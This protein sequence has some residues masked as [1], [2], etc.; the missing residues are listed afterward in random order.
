MKS[1]SRNGYLLLVFSMLFHQNSNAQKPNTAYPESRQV[2]Q[3]DTYHGT[4][5]ND[6]YRWLED[7][8]A[9]ETT[10]WVNR[11]NA[12]TLA[13]LS[14]IPFRDSLKTE[15][16]GYW[17][18]VRYQTPFRCGDNFFYY[19]QDGQQNQPVL[20]Y[21]KSLEF[22]PFSYF[23]PNKLSSDGTTA[24]T[25]TVPS[26]DGK[27]LVFQVSE[28]GS[29]W[30][31][32][33]IKETKSMKTL[34]EVIDGVKFSS[35][36]WFK[37]GF[38]YSKY[39]K[40]ETGNAANEYHSV[41][42][43]RLGTA[44]TQDSLVWQDKEHPR[45]NFN[46]S[47]TDDERYLV[48]SGSESTSGNSV[49][50]QDL[51]VKSSSPRAIVKSFEYDFDLMGNFGEELVFLTNHKAPRKRII[52]INPRAIDEKN[53]TV[54]LAESDEIIQ[55]ASLCWRSIVVHT[56]KDASSRLYIHNQ[57]GL[58][59]HTVP[60]DGFG[61]VE[62]ISGS[63][64]DS[65]M[66]FS[67]TTFTQPATVYRY[68]LNN[69][70]MAV[71]FKSTLPYA[72][73]DFMTSQVFYNSKDGT[74]IPMFLVH[75]KGLKPNGKLP[76]LLFGYGGFN[77][78]KT[79]EFKPERM[80]LLNH[81]G[82]F[83]LPSLRGG[84]E[85]GSEWHDAG[86]KLRKQNVFDDFIAAAEYLISE[87]YTSPATLGI[88]GRSNGGLL[89][90][91]SMTQR[92][93]LFKVALPAV[94][95]MDMLRF[96]K[97]TIGWAWTRD[98]GSSDDP[99]E[100]NA[101]YAYSPYHRLKPETCYPATLVTTADHDDR[102]VPG[103]SFKFAARLQEVQSCSNPALI[104]VD[105]DAGHGSGKPLSKLLDEQSDIFAFLLYHLGVRL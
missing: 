28:A 44:P 4:V 26:R 3:N 41:Y 12:F 15:M 1:L 83:A 48:I 70:R 39:P 103:H 79:P 38:F 71:Q 76:T 50:V 55:S 95:V 6:P 99:K 75:K 36:S 42:Y 67:Y 13:H 80:V 10:D 85:Y 25:Q 21:M 81:G 32:I 101:L 77:I 7:D 31:S 73:D 40:A 72:A 27:H 11:Q 34:P 105:T 62:G 82:V 78:S 91:A 90:G 22:V 87:G 46:A 66:F 94:G 92:P 18:Y 33:R 45:R 61:T 14:T 20:Y 53:W 24:L 35:I 69:H 17:N 52:T 9:R 89:V 68:Q 5:V 59:T 102:V 96:Q 23:D 56:M 51:S 43:H 74:R 88:A 57:K 2:Q 47:V 98:Y 100:F 29:D 84:G 30:N 97:F 37:D 19:R 49:F 64:R 65:L 8:R 58:R 86:T 63:M 93:E 16:Q 104:R 60:L 54:I